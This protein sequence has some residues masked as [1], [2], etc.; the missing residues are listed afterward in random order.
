MRARSWRKSDTDNSTSY[1]A[2]MR[3]HLDNKPILALPDNHP[4]KRFLLNHAEFCSQWIGFEISYP[5]KEE[6][7]DL[8]WHSKSQ[9]KSVC[10]SDILYKYISF[11]PVLSDWV[12]NPKTQTESEKTYLV[13]I[14]VISTLINEAQSC[15]PGQIQPFHNSLIRSLLRLLNNWESSITAR[16]THH[17]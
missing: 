11:T 10:L 17:K 15:C 16:I 5:D 1:H 4:A 8:V 3:I 9:N 6:F 7:P 13:T 14:A 2:S 12:L